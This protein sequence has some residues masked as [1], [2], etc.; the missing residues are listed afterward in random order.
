LRLSR[1]NNKIKI[2]LSFFKYFAFL[3]ILLCSINLSAQQEGDRIIAVIGNDVI[4]ESDLNIQALLFARQNNLKELNEQVFQQVFQNMYVEKLILAKAEQDSIFVTEEE[5]QN[6]LDYRLKTLGEQYGSEKNLEEAF[7]MTI[8]KMKTMFKDEI[9]KKIKIDKMKQ[10]KF[11]SGIRI[12][13]T[14]I[15]DFFQK[16]KDSLPPVSETFELYELV[17]IPSLSEEAKKIAYEKAKMIYDSL[18]MG[19]D[20][21]DLAKRYSDDSTS[22]VQGG[23]LGKIKKGETVKEFEDVVFLL[24]PG[25]TSEIT[26]TQFGYH[27][28]KVL[29]K[30]GDGA[31]VQHILISFP[32]LESADFEAINY[33]KEIK[34]KV[35]K[36]EKK[37]QELAF[38]FSQSNESRPDSGYIGRIS[39]SNLDSNE[40]NSL[41]NLNKGEVSD[42]VRIGDDRNYVYSIF[43]VKDRIPEHAISLKDDYA[44]LER[45]A[46]T[47]KENKE[48]NNWIEEIKKSVYVEIKM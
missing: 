15:L 27:I 3:L 1:N 25:E 18:K 45:Y 32:R 6:Q 13:R 16:F 17:R 33:L 5:I 21:S 30:L 4:L 46:T 36:G 22:A 11:G 35:L 43:Y 28:I 29:E 34:S 44:V 8:N 26:E 40:I 48:L 2:K 7:G 24:K 20:F 19:A 39:A 42:P 14:E 37:F 23:N 10:K 41:K 38:E 31:K 9:A 12:T 47:F